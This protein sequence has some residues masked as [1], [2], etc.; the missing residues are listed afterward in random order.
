MVFFGKK[1]S[2]F[3]YW[4]FLTRNGTSGVLIVS[5]IVFIVYLYLSTYE[6][7][8]SSRPS[9]RHSKKL[10][11]KDS[12]KTSRKQISYEHKKKNFPLED[13]ENDLKVK[14]H[15]DEERYELSDEDFDTL[16][17]H[18]KRKVHHDLDGGRYWHKYEARHRR[19]MHDSD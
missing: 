16:E 1:P 14:T 13:F 18:H 6:S 15:H 17:R 5:I 2:G 3:S 12:S 9:K 7:E 11:K 4:D 19:H 8:K 10:G